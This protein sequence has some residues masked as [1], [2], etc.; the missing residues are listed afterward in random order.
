MANKD[1]NIHTWILA[2]ITFWLDSPNPGWNFKWN[3]GVFTAVKV[4]TID[5][6]NLLYLQ[7]EVK[8]RVVSWYM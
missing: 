8:I 4:E 1:G 3:G 5:K 6:E 2:V 7:D